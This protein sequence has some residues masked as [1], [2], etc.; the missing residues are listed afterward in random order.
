MLDM[1]EQQMPDTVS[2][3]DD[4]I[5]AEDYELLRCGAH[6]LKGSAAAIGANNVLEDARNLEK[7][8]SAGDEKAVSQF[9]DTLKAN[10]EKMY[11]AIREYKKQEKRA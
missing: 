3:L 10:L 6:K 11:Q 4:A 7:A 5:E 2:E 1:F 8:D 9:T